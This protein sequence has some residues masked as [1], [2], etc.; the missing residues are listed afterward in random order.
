MFPVACRI[1][2]LHRQERN[3]VKD[4][5]VGLRPHVGQPAT[6][7][8]STR[9]M[10]AAVPSPPDLLHVHRGVTWGL[11]C[12]LGLLGAPSITAAAPDQ[13]ARLG[14]VEAQGPAVRAVT[15]IHH[16]PAM[17]AA[18]KGTAVQATSSVG[19][20]LDRIRRYAIDPTTGHATGELGSAST[21]LNPAYGFFAGA[22]FYFEPLA[23]AIAYYDLSDG[24]RLTGAETLRYHLAPAAIDG[25][26][27]QSERCPLEGSMKLR[28]DLSVAL[29]FDRGNLQIGLAVHFPLV[30]ERFAYDNDTELQRRPDELD[31]AGCDAKEDPDCAERIGFRG[32]NHWIPRNGAPPGFDAVL[33]VGVAFQFR[34]DTITLGARYRTAPLSN[35]GE[36]RLG[37]DG[38]VCR[39][40]LDGTT[41]LDTTRPC[42]TA[43][44]VDATLRTRL[45]QQVA[46][47]TSMLLGPARDWKLD[48]Q[49]Y[50][51]D[52]CPG[53]LRPGACDNR[54]ASRL[55]LLGLDRTTATAP[56]TLRYRG[57]QDL[58]GAE[59]Y[60]THRLRSG[61]WLLLGSMLSSPSVRRAAQTSAHGEGWRLGL[62]A[63][64]RIRTR[65]AKLHISPG[66][67]LDVILPRRV[68]PD[69]AAFDPVAAARFA[70]SGGDL[71]E[72]GAQT[73][74]DGLGRPTNAGRYFG[75]AH[76]FSVTLG[77]ADDAAVLE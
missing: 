12:A 66:Y 37:G 13:G 42:A 69:D 73:V 9:H 51:M 26:G 43:R 17:L 18:L 25:C 62:N 23:L 36:L 21:L 41:P 46:I 61:L 71:N 28:Q 47:G 8:R 70:E 22:S 34:R 7:N 24:M 10:L 59:V 53:G 56:D 39:P 54:D 44:A 31:P 57:S 58:Y 5:I 45:P 27:N 48:I 16:N 6:Q 20:S 35:G 4:I 64:T 52:L 29:A 33:S 63:G 11:G 67:A 68:R 50:W 32:W 60:V 65:R 55:R 74:L 76:I 2:S 19:L 30:F 15:A 72:D 14:G 3:G 49:L 77:W 1:A 75:M 38:I 40:E